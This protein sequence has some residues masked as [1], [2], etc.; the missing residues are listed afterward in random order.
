MRS[1]MSHTDL[2]IGIDPGTNTGVAVKQGESMLAILAFKIHT[3]MWF[4]REVAK[5]HPHLRI[6]VRIEDS[7]QNKMKVGREEYKKQMA[8]VKGV[9]SINRDCTIW[10]DYMN[11]LKKE[12][13]NV[14][15]EMLPVIGRMNGRITKLRPTKVSDDELAR[16]L[17]VRHKHVFCNL[18]KFE[19]K[20]KRRN[21]L[22]HNSRDAA[23]IARSPY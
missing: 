2:I 5:A 17:G 8:K 23:V 22:N 6:K 1:S 16:I 10:E 18:P 9:G 12:F 19:F 14:E 7:R 3:A 20:V 11:D 15:F 21:P 4:V 13:A